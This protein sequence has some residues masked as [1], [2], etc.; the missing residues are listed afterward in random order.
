MVARLDYRVPSAESV[1]QPTYVLTLRQSRPPTGLK[2]HV[3]P[4]QVVERPK[5]GEHEAVI[6]AQFNPNVKTLEEEAPVGKLMVWTDG[7]YRLEMFSTLPVEE[8]VKVAGS[9]H[10]DRYT[11]D[12][13]WSHFSPGCTSQWSFCLGCPGGRCRLI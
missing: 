6:Y 1:R 4:E 13:R 2:L 11:D 8:M 7:E 3:P 9:L 10:V 12:G 5:T